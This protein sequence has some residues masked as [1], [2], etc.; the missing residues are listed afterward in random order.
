ML[1]MGASPII[2]ALAERPGVHSQLWVAREFE[3]CLIHIRSVSKENRREGER[4]KD[5]ER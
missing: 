2:L 4:E 5:K 1:G 3:V